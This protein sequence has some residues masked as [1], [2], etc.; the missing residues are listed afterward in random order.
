MLPESFEVTLR[1]V[2]SESPD[3]TTLVLDAPGHTAYRAGQYV[4]IAPHQF[5]ALVPLIKELELG[6]GRKEP[7]RKYSLMSAPHED[8]IAL[9]VKREGE[10]RYAPLLSPHLV[11]A[12]KPGDRF[13]VF[14][15]SGPYVLDDAFGGLVVHVVAGCGAVPNFS[16]VKDAL[17]RDLPARHVWV[18]SNKTREDVLYGAQLD[19]LAAGGKLKVLNTLTREKADGFRSGRVD[20][21]LLE[22]AIPASER[23]TCLVYVCG[24]GVQPW[25]R[26]AALENGT[27]VTPRFMEGVMGHLKAMGIPDKRIKREVYG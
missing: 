20:R 22:E 23:E 16:I 13:T 1:E 18:A 17:F 3:T 24:P 19:A 15:Y 25:D 26:R 6:K 2:R 21:A 10:G 27:S 4:S 5:D 8:G 9:T 12:L 11:S 7:T 14:G